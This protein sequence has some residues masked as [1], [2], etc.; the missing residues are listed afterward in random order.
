MKYEDIFSKT[1]ET[2]WMGMKR[3]RSRISPDEKKN[4]AAMCMDYGPPPWVAVV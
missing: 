3:M 4:L 2:V 1:I